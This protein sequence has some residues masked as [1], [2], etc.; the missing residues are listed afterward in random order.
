MIDLILSDSQ[1]RPDI[2]LW[3]GA[4]PSSLIIEWESRNSVTLPEDLKYL[5]SLKGG[6]DLFESET[7]LQP[8]GALDEYDLVESVTQTFRTR[9]LSPEF[10]VFQTGLTDSVFR[11]SD[12]AIFSLGAPNGSTLQPFADLNEWYKTTLRETFATRYGL[13]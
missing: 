10:W 7:I 13:R 9:G 5:W 4:L 3:R 12:G 8:F 2:F 11:I 6:G 1:A